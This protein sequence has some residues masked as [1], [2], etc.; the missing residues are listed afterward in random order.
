MTTSQ[1]DHIP[2]IPISL[3]TTHLNSSP[4]SP[5]ITFPPHHQISTHLPPHYP[6]LCLWHHPLHPISPDTLA[7]PPFSAKRLFHRLPSVHSSTN[8]SNKGCTVWS[9]ERSNF[10]CLSC[11]ACT[12]YLCDAGSGV[13]RCEVGEQMCKVVVQWGYA[14]CGYRYCAVYT[15]HLPRTC[16]HTLCTHTCTHTLSPHLPS[17]HTYPLPTPTLCKKSIAL[18]AKPAC[19]TCDT[20]CRSNPLAAASVHTSTASDASCDACCIAANAASRCAVGILR[21]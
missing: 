7:K 10:A 15:L 20:P 13:L 11:S 16:T 2:T 5:H 9:V 12:P 18:C 3:C 14:L 19:T 1:V 21:W 17:P 4:A 6:S 8:S